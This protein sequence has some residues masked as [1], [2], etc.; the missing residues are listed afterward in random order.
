MNPQNPY[1]GQPEQPQQPGQW[2]PP[3]QSQPQPAPP[4][5]PG[6]WQPPAQQPAPPQWQPPQEQQSPSQ[7]QP[8]ERPAY[9]RPEEKG[10]HPMVVL[11]P[12][13]QMVATMKRHP[14]GIIS[15]YISAGL[16][17]LVAGALAF[18]LLPYLFNQYGIVGETSAVYAGFGLVVVLLVVILAVA[19]SV[20]WENQWVVTTDSITQISQRSLF[21]RQVSQLSMDNLEDV[22]VDQNGILP[23]MF[24]YG[25]LKVETAGERAKF[26]FSYCPNPNEC[27]RRI[28]EVHEQFLDER[29]NIQ[30]HP[31]DVNLNS[32]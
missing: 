10:L 22:T 25:I 32:S 11:Q 19:T 8:A 7:W 20:Y 29:R 12:G 14:F 21:G 9:A 5:D 16:G 2:Q 6:Q 1:S 18:G 13:E 30:N 15:L 17:I 27:A 28:L 23:H 3:Q 26:V 24:N 31:R 4:A